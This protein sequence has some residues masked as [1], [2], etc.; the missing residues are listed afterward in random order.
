MS[1]TTLSRYDIELQRGHVALEFPSGLEQEYRK[2]HLLQIIG[3]ARL[4]LAVLGGLALLTGVYRLGFVGHWGANIET[5]LRVGV[6][7]PVCA[8]MLAAAWHSD[9]EK[10]YPPT[11]FAGSLL[12]AVA[13][14]TL[15]VLMIR[16]GTA[17]G[18]TFLSLHVFAVFMLL[19]ML[20]WRAAIVA[21]TG[22]AVFVFTS[23]LLGLPAKLLAYETGLLTL[24]IIV[25]AYIAYDVELMNRRAFLERG[26]LGDL[27][28]RDGLTGLRN[29]RAFDE[30]L[31][32]VWQQSLR[33]RSPIAVLLIDID[34]FKPYNDLYGHQAGDSCLKLVAQLVQG[35]ARR[36][37]DL[38]ARYGGEELAVVLYQ[39][40]AD[41]ARAL[42][43][44]LR[45]SVEQAR[46]E[47][48]G[49]PGRG[50]LTVSVGVAWLE[51]T[52]DRTPNDAVQLADEALYSAKE[53][54]RNQVRFLGPDHSASFT[55][56]LRRLPSDKPARTP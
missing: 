24:V 8:A 12:L 41:H 16:E 55:A 5:L 2:R 20:F 38:A 1:Q 7:L 33:D 39:V 19:G 26:A 52:L 36:P 44:Q 42:A 43:E 56:T 54:G 48:R 46:V 32:R 15:I 47:H 4:W 30:Q 28:E 17:N 9:F 18:V 11:L 23:L 49:A 21:V 3:R 31:L 51:A 34:H 53:A 29:R 22:L 50:L 6:L 10:L 37:L 25:A 27:A 35:F 14:S 13:S 40:T 45:A